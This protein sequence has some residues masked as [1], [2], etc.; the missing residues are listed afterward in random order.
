NHQ[1]R[2]MP[3]G[4]TREDME[5]DAGI[6][7]RLA[8]TMPDGLLRNLMVRART[9]DVRS[10][11]PRNRQSPG[12]R[13]PVAHVWFRTMAPLPDSQP[14]HRAILAYAS[15]FQLLATAIQPHGLSFHK[16]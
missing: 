4:H 2:R 5:L 15:D 10:V 9:I 11:E 16:G 13:E 14:I 1:T 12:K 3:D 6:R 8:E 7:N